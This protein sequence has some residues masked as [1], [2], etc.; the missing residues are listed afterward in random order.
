MLLMLSGCAI[1]TAFTGALAHAN[2]NNSVFT[3][4]VE[5]F[6]SFGNGAIVVPSLTLALYAAPDNYIGTVG[7]LSLS[8]RF[9]GGSVGTAIFFNVSHLELTN[10]SSPDALT[11]SF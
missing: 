2:P 9:L 1:M 7:A 8:S 11:P 6:A 10:H 3:V 5:T 4:T